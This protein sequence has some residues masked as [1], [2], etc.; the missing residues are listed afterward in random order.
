MDNIK[1]RLTLDMLTSCCST[2]IFV[3]KGDTIRELE[4]VLSSHGKP[5][6]LSDEC[7]VSVR[8]KL[9]DGTVVEG[10]GT[11]EDNTIRYVLS[12]ELT[13]SGIVNT[14]VKIT[15]GSSVVTSPRFRIV[16][17]DTLTNELI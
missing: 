4:M 7:S 12:S 10:I 14:E 1:H 13:Y 9:A 17:A 8:S 2:E 3:K 5:I 11:V 16:V 15:E 6:P